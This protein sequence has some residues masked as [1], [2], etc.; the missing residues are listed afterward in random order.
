MK[1]I[2]LKKIQLS[3]FKS[4]NLEVEFNEGAT[5]ISGK[6]GLGK[7]SIASAFYW[8]LS[9]YTSPFVPKNYALFDDR[10]ELTHETPLAKV[11]AWLKVGDLDYTIEKTAEAKFTRP[12][13]SSEWVKASSDTYA[14]YIDEIETSAT[15]YNEWISNNIC[16][17]EFLPYAMCGDF[18]SYL[19]TEDKGKARKVLTELVG[20]IKSEDFKGD[21]SSIAELMER[22]SAG[23]IIEMSKKKKKPLE[24]RQNVIPV[25]IDRKEERLSELKSMDFSATER[26]IEKIKG[27]IEAIDGLLLGNA[28]AVKPI[29]EHNREI[30]N[31]V[32]NKRLSLVNGRLDYKEAQ[33][34]RTSEIKAKIAEIKRYNEGIDKENNKNKRDWEEEI[35]T[36]E[37]Y[38]RQL[39]RLTAKREELLKRRDEVKGRV[40]AEETCAYCGQELPYEMLEK[41]RAK[42]NETKAKDLELIVAEGKE[43]AEEISKTKEKIEYLGKRIEAGYTLLEKQDLTPY[44]E[45]LARVE[46]TFVPYEETDEF[47]RINAE[48]ETLMSEIKE[49]PSND[50]ESLTSKKKALIEDLSELSKKLGLKD[51]IE[52]VEKDIEDLKKELRNVACS[53][54]EL[55]GQIFKCKEWEQERN[56]ITA[57]RINGKMKKARF[58]MWS[59][60]KNGDLVPDLILTNEYGT[61]FSTTNFANRIELT[62][63]LQEL[64][65]KTFDVNMPRFIDE[66][67][68]FSPSNL[69]KFEDAQSIFLFASDEDSLTIR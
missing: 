13:G 34:A 31:K 3:N 7:T 1:T 65:C 54:A 4:L 5:K 22:Y 42:F 38:E 39:S 68:V 12:K 63:D 18:F 19:V 40:Y 15:A 8:L 14:V 64:F 69:P 45:A 53:I 48:I 44:E 47:K 10:V 59:T 35:E 55:E 37:V 21:Y 26:E 58:E 2:T 57:F 17:V 43:V 51:E 52:K 6:N 16:T 60:Q 66:S 24:D 50:N 11:K 62:L 28:D 36:K 27:D 56:E 33:N 25:E 9:S 20:E 41:A 61:R 29:L 30:E 67:A 46:A 32:A 23:E 49:V